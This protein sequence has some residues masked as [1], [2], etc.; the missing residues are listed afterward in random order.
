M[1]SFRQSF[2]TRQWLKWSSAIFGLHIIFGL[3]VVMALNG[4]AVNNILL[5][6]FKFTT[7]FKLLWPDQPLNS[8]NFIATK[9]IFAFAHTDARSGLNLW[10]L[11]YNSYTLLVYI[12]LSLLLGWIVTRVRQKMMN[13][14]TVP[15]ILVLIGI[16]FTAASISYM[17]VIDHCTSANWVG[18]VALYGLGL[19][20]F[21]LYPFYQY[22]C[23]ILGLLGLLVGFL[24]QI[25]FKH[26][27]LQF[28][29]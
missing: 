10:T 18:F 20:E 14:S 16:A 28:N 21:Q 3:C 22:V 26:R 2:D 13:I 4:D 29:P 27:A 24:L 11:E 17:S 6:I 12:A 23:A 9:S 15:L 19:N 8:L 25:H 7:M 5:P 1:F